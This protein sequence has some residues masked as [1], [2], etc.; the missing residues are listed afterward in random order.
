MSNNTDTKYYDLHTKGA[1]FLSRFREVKPKAGSG[2]KFKPFCSVNIGAFR[3]SS[4]NVEYTNFDTV[5][6]GTKALEVLKKYQKEINDQN[7]KVIVGFTIGDTYGYTFTTK[8]KDTQQDE[9]RC[10][11]KGRFLSVQF[12]KINGEM[13]YKYE[14]PTTE[15]NEETDTQA[16]PEQSE[17]TTAAEPAPEKA[18][19][20]E[21]ESNV[22]EAQ[23]T[24]I[25]DCPFDE[26][27][28]NTVSLSQDDPDFDKKKDWLKAQ[29][30]K[31]NSEQ[32]CWELPTK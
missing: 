6:S 23:A 30:Y 10:G 32:Q 13:V 31:W 4:E 14:K 2:N 25:E 27:L 29:G 21:A 1:G 15:D 28:S 12:L 8:N 17:K 11:I 20:P 19:D 16:Q 9:N 26:Q 24:D 3:G 7:T 18:K 22:D 5:I